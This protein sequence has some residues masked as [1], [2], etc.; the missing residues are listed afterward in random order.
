MEFETIK[1]AEIKISYL[2]IESICI[3]YNYFN[4]FQ[5]IFHNFQK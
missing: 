1:L 2:L 3:L 4:Y 5:I